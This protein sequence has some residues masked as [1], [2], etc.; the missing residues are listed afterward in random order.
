MAQLNIRINDDLKNSA[1]ILFED[2][3]LNISTA[4]NMFIRQAVRQG[5]IPFEI[6]TKVDD[7]FW[8]EAN[9]AHLRKAV[10]ALNAG[11]GLI[12]KTMEELKAMEE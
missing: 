7:P 12:E 3:G 10:A 2:L 5:S 1:E 4:V 8:S 11:E 6:T 9:Q